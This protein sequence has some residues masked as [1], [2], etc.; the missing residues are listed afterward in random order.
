MVNRLHHG[1]AMGQIGLILIHHHL[2]IH[3]HFDPCFHI[4]DLHYHQILL[5]DVRQHLYYFQTDRH[6]HQI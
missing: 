1:V 2:P 6:H 4:D 3:W 5:M